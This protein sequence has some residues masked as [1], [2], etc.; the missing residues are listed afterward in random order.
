MNNTPFV[1]GQKHT[2]DKPAGFTTIQ[3]A[4]LLVLKSKTEAQRAT[5]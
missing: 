1:F 3:L 4:R 2:T 5:Q